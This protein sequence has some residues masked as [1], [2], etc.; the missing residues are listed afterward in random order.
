MKIKAITENLLLTSIIQQASLCLII[1]ILYGP[2]ALL[3]SCIALYKKYGVTAWLLIHLNRKK[4]AK[5]FQYHQ[6]CFSLSF[7]LQFFC[8]LSL[9]KIISFLF[10]A[11][12]PI[13][14]VNL[15]QYPKV[16]SSFQIPS[17]IPFDLYSYCLRL[18]Y[19]NSFLTC[20]MF[21][22]PFCNITSD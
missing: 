20:L 4:K 8:F 15:I 17:Q 21:F 16:I 18:N 14:P 13:L 1:M 9:I 5:K 10:L 22:Q 7:S 3:F 12:Y 11:E 6:T 19:F 2:R